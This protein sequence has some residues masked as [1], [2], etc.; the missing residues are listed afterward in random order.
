MK[1]F[2][3]T[4][5]G[6][7]LITAALVVS[8]LALAILLPG[9]AAG[10]DDPDLYLPLIPKRHILEPQPV[11]WVTILEENFEGAFPGPWT[12]MDLNPEPKEHLWGKR[13][14]RV[15]AGS[16]SGWA[17]GGGADGESLG[18]GAAYPINVHS[19]M[20]YGPFSMADAIDGE[21]SI[22]AWVNTEEDLDTLFVAA[23]FDRVN[24]VGIEISG[25]SQGWTQV[26]L[27]LSNLPG[28][29]AAGR[30]Q[31]WVALAFLSDEITTTGE[32]VYVDNILLRKAIPDTLSTVQ[33]IP[34]APQLPASL[35]IRSA[36]RRMPSY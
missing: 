21:L 16:Y 28:G 7:Q 15:Y 12:L 3:R 31:V 17:V 25:Q 13:S 14:C 35:S 29:S 26:Q 5:F 9:P 30:P 1:P 24:Y 10:N 19:W 4:L 8:C 2:L 22:R 18:C 23:S 34:Q 27:D 33:T 32:G 11:T 20:V 36:Y 6:H